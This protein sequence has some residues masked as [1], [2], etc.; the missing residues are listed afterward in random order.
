[1]NLFDEIRGDIN[2]LVNLVCE[3]QNY[4]TSVVMKPK[5]ATDESHK[6]EIQRQLRISELSRNLGL[7]S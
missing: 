6:K 1:M 3:S 7:T 2:E 4:R 5:L